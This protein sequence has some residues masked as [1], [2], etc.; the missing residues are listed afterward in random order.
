MGSSDPLNRP[1]AFS[2]SAA[3]SPAR[4]FPAVVGSPEH[5]PDRRR[6]KAFR[7]FREKQPATSPPAHNCGWNSIRISNTVM[8]TLSIS[9]FTRQRACSMSTVHKPGDLLDDLTWKRHDWRLITRSTLPT[10]FFNTYTL[11]TKQ[12]E[13][14]LPTESQR[15]QS[16]S[17][18]RE[19]LQ[20]AGTC[21][22]GPRSSC[23]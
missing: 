21:D 20:N 6:P 12:P 5:L 11:T 9:L 23:E 1:F 7:T 19:G 10:F 14:H 22:L 18:I 4:S 17:S 13:S 15:C 8:D 2:E 16:L 3:S